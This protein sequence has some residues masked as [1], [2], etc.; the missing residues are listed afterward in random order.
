MNF[1]V[2]TLFVVHKQVKP[3]LLILS[4]IPFWGWGRQ[5][6]SSLNRTGSAAGQAFHLQNHLWAALCARG[7]LRCAWSQGRWQPWCSSLLPLK[8][9]Q[10]CAPCCSLKATIYSESTH[11]A[12]FGG[13]WCKQKRR[14]WWFYISGFYNVIQEFLSLELFVCYSYKIVS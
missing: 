3:F 8:T 1:L 5:P 11:K 13:L 9:L 12:E 7:P 2:T 4:E 14:V 6:W 10:T